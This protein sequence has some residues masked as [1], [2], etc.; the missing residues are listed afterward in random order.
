MKKNVG[1]II[2]VIVLI[3][4]LLFSTV[5]SASGGFTSSLSA[6]E[7]DSLAF[8]NTPR[9]SFTPDPCSPE[10]LSEQVAHVHALTREFEDT[11]LLL[12]STLLGNTS[13]SLVHDLQRIRRAAEDQI[14]P[15]CLTD[16]K[17]YQIVHMNARIEVFG[18]A[19]S[20]FNAYGSSGDLFM[21][22]G[23]TYKQDVLNAALEPLYAKAQV[24]AKQ[25]EIEYNRLLG[26]TPVPPMPAP[27]TPK[28]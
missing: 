7:T 4:M 9:P 18:T 21:P 19:L 13:V 10:S 12:T 17:A 11:A 25:Y 3:L 1:W 2:T 28:P 26:F 15:S 8:T 23:V 22:D 14:V 6:A 16:L 5:F 24:A 27:A 20:F